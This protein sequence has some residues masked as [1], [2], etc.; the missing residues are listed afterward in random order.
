MLSKTLYFHIEISLLIYVEISYVLISFHN[1][2]IN[3]LF[4]S[5]LS[6]YMLRLI[7]IIYIENI[8][9]RFVICLLFLHIIYLA[10]YLSRLSIQIAL[11]QIWNAALLLM[12]PWVCYHI[13]PYL[14]SL[15]YKMEV[16]IVC[17]LYGCEN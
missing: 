2:V 10:W 14:S 6:L 11:V 5:F 15:T 1:S 7:I 9:S 8:V 16:I 12:W 4:L 17:T 13:T 3:C